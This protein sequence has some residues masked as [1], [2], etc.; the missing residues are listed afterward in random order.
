MGERGWFPHFLRALN[1]WE[2]EEVHTFISLIHE[3]ESPPFS[4]RYV[5]YERG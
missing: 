2:V 5:A 4:I 3:K 1:N